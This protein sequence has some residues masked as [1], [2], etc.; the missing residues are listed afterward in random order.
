[1]NIISTPTKKVLSPAESAVLRSLA[2]HAVFN[3]PQKKEE[4][5]RSLDDGTL[6]PTD[7]SAAVES[8]VAENI[9]QCC[10]SRTFYW[11]ATPSHSHAPAADRLAQ[12]ARCD[13]A[14]P[15]AYAIG[16]TLMNIPFVHAVA[17]S[18]SL[19]KG[20]LSENSDYDFFILTHPN[21]LWIARTL[22][23]LYRRLLPDRDFLCPNYILSTNACD[24]PCRDYYT[25]LEMATIIP[26]A[27]HTYF[28]TM[29]QKNSWIADYTPN[30]PMIEPYESPKKPLGRKLAEM[31]L[32]APQGYILDRIL[33]IISKHW[34]SLRI[35]NIKSLSESE[36]LVIDRNIWKG[37]MSGWKNKILQK[38]QNNLD[39]IS[40]THHVAINR[41]Q[42]KNKVLFASAYYYRLDHKQWAFAQPYPPLGCLYAA[43]VARDAGF[44]VAVFDA[45]LQKNEHVFDK[46]FATERP[47][48]VVIHE[49]GF[50]YLTKMCLLRMREAAM[51]MIAIAR[52]NGAKVVVASSD[53]TDHPD[54]YLQAGAHVVIRGETE[55][56]LPALLH[57]WQTN[58]PITA[59]DG[60]CYH[61]PESG[62]IVHTPDR[63]KIKDLDSL[64]APAWDLIDLAP[65]KA[66][67]EKKH[68]RFSLNIATTRGCP[69]TCNWCAKPIYG[70]RYT[71]RTP[72]KVVDEIA[73]LT[74]TYGASHFWM[75]DDIFGINSGWVQ[76]FNALVQERGL[77]FTY[78]IQSRADLLLRDGNTLDALAQSGLETVWIGAESGS[79]AILDAMDKGTTVD[80]IRRVV[81]EIQKRGMKA[82][83]F[84]QYGYLGETRADI[85][86]T[87]DMILT[88]MPHNIGISVSYPLPGTP[89]HEKVQKTLQDKTNWQDSNDLDMMFA[90]T[91]SPAYYRVL[92]KYTHACF[93]AK[94]ATLALQA[95]TGKS[96]H[97][98]SFKSAAKHIVRL[99]KYMPIKRVL[100]WRLQK[101]EIPR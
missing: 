69:Y 12:N 30:I 98:P 38:Q 90:G 64:P 10:D 88:L 61:A 16:K 74:S 60:I 53:S 42:T 55:T 68:G 33:H 13:A 100:K 75:T 5:W 97:R 22:I 37:H 39:H 95:Y 26:I 81:P 101:L 89:F 29:Q 32:C 6:T 9:V 43:A 67:W 66:I 82:A 27:G 94:K 31:L 71:S 96:A 7:V 1:M 91:Y 17:L 54:L 8:L 56:T 80:Q 41:G 79:Q 93:H 83:L 51:H 72:E 62:N 87:L 25:A 76:R 40:N 2:Y 73:L 78:T 20:V 47:E 46:A 49:Y 21:R 36:T 59:I 14:I 70:R 18:G 65:Y 3:Y 77:K 57:A 24:L 4:I 28:A 45:G 35:R 52:A 84:I 85:A 63:Q 44:D 23:N 11:L 58:T 15:Q 34:L 99:L 50:N 19:S 48:I 92:Y 86:Q